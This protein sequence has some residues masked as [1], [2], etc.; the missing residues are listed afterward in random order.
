MPTCHDGACAQCF[1]TRDC[2]AGQACINGT[3]H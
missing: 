3:C 2:P 1:R